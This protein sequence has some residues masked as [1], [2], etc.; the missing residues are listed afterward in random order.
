M[1][2]EKA[3]KKFWDVY[4]NY[5]RVANPYENDEDDI[6]EKALIEALRVQAEEIFDSFEVLR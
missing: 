3:R 6:T 1:T 4:E 2:D 5:P